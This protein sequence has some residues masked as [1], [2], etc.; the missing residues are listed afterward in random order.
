MDS[1][2]SLIDEAV[3]VPEP[4]ARN[5]S[6]TSVYVALSRAMEAVVGAT[7][8]NWL[9]FGAWASASAGAVIRGERV[10]D[11]WA[12][13]DVLSGNTA[14]IADIGPR[15]ARFL[16][17]HEVSRGSA[18]LDSLVSRDPR[19]NE[20]SELADAFSCYAA[21]TAGRPAQ[22]DDRSRAQ[23][24]LRANVQVAH[25]E[26]RFADPLIDAAIPGGWLLGTMA[27]QAVIVR[28]PDGNLHVTRDVPRPTYLCGEQWPA[29]LNALDDPAL[30]TLA[31]RYGQ[32]TDTAVSSNAP[33]W[34]DLNERMGFI[35]CLFRAYQRDPALRGGP[36]MA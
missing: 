27:S 12:A 32:D 29:E 10:G 19:L 21:L 31:R 4:Q 9:H 25:H 26:Q 34:Q 3:S 13:Q 33:D 8:A 7:D 15:F 16:R 24:M 30:V 14:I 28:L 5:R 6:I 35:F 11:R 2:E 36:P 20:S 22:S 1:L 23:M 18:E 17:L